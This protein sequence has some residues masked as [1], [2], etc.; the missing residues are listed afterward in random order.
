MKKI[1]TI[2][3]M[4]AF[5]SAFAQT[6]DTPTDTTA[7]AVTETAPTM[8]PAPDVAVAP[9]SAEEH[10]AKAQELAAQAEVAYPI[11]FYDRDL[12]KA[13]V[14]E[15]DAAATAEPEREYLS[16]LAQLYTTTQWW[17]SGYRIW[18]E[19]GDL[20]DEEKAWA[21]DTAAHL[22]YM[23]LQQNDKAKAREYVQQGLAWMETDSLKA[24]A[25]RVM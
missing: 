12:W 10:F 14:T 15:A 8:A 5:G 25:K 18:V 1:L 7:P 23:R 11:P 16:Y 21:A 22:A 19:L 6:T 4:I 2:S 20:T 13:A 9:A 3:L 24:L 17:I